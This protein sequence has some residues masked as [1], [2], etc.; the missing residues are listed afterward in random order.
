M[1]I[2]V[3]DVTV[4]I[5][6]NPII[7]AARLDVQPATVTGLIGPNGSGKSTLLRCVYRALKPSSGSVYIGSD[8]VW[9][10]GA[11]QA[12]RRT[13]VVTQD[14]DL[15]N[16]FSVEE[17]VAMGRGPHKRLLERENSTDRDIVQDALARVGMQWAAHRVFAR[18]SGGERQRVL[19][20]RALAQ[21]A[22]VLLLDEP[23][24]HLD[25]GSQLDLL[26]LVRELGLTTIAALHDLDHA[27]AYC[28]NLALLRSGQVVATGK[29]EEVLEPD[30]VAD[31][32]GVRST[33][34][35]HPI[36]G[37]PHFVTAPT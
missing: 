8:E 20:A 34:V 35:P 24:N 3:H 27:T 12:G 36:T 14:H 17:T 31:V 28:D 9:R 19:V 29:P 6:G 33:I 23:T 5:D 37:R 4:I 10:S 11:R 2:E 22:P 25:V 32:F 1:R 13:A 30:R 16:D 26:S 18:L 7:G 21:Q 15:D